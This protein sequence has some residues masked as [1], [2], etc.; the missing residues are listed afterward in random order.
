MDAFKAILDLPIGQQGEALSKAGNWR[1]LFKP[2]PVSPHKIVDLSP[3][4]IDVSAGTPAGKIGEIPPKVYDLHPG[5]VSKPKKKKLVKA[6]SHKEEGIV[7]VASITNIVDIMNE[8]GLSFDD[9]MKEASKVSQDELMD[10]VR[11]GKDLG[12]EEEQKAL[13]NLPGKQPGEKTA[14]PLQKI[15]DYL[16]AVESDLH[17]EMV[18]EGI[19]SYPI[20]RFSTHP[21]AAF[22]SGPIQGPIFAAGI[23][24]MRKMYPRSIRGRM[25]NQGKGLWAAEREMIEAMKAKGRKK[26]LKTGLI[27]GG[28]GGA[29]VGAGAA[30]S[31]DQQKAAAYGVSRFAT[32]PF[33]GMLIPQ[34]WA[35]NLPGFNAINR[36]VS[37]RGLAGR[38]AKGKGLMGEEQRLIAELAAKGRKEGLTKGLIAGGAGGAAAGAAGAAMMSD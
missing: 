23:G 16:D 18:K 30:S 31:G 25:A 35:P 7:S 6:G 20:S 21:L 2:K 12:K 4:Q 32:H 19:A 1:R 9:L 3:S 29:V 26:G 8:T 15:A 24:G 28:A 34:F 5:T 14:G 27:A 11:A 37:Q 17:T 33:G 13:K 10:D 38:F 36:F 22:I